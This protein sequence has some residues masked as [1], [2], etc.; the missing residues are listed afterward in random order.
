[1]PEAETASVPEASGKVK[2]RAA[3]AVP[4]NLK[5]LVPVPPRYR[6]RKG[7]ALEP[8]SMLDEP[9]SSDVLMATELR[10]DKAVFAPPLP[11]KQ[12]PLDVQTEYV[13]AASAGRFMVT[14]AV[15]V[16]KPKVVVKPPDVPV[17][18]LAAVPCR[19][20]TWLVAPAVKA[21]E[22]VIEFKAD[23]EVMSLLAPDAA[24]PKLLR[25]PA[26]VPLLVPPLAIG[27][28]PVKVI[29][30]VALR[31]TFPLAE[32]ASVPPAFGMVIVRSALSVAGCKVLIKAEEP[33]R[34]IAFPRTEAV[35][36]VSP[37]LPC[38]TS[39]PPMVM[40]EPDSV[41]ILSPMTCDPVNLARAPVV[42]PAVVTPPPVPAQ[43]PLE[44][45]S[46]YVPAES[47][48]KFKVTLAVGVTK[49]TVVTF[50]PF[51]AVIM[52]AAVPCRVK[53]W[54]VAPAVKAA[55]GVIVLRPVA[56]AKAEVEVMSPLAPLAAAPR[57]LRAPAAVPL[58]VPPLAI[59]RRP[60]KD[61]PPVALKAMF[62]EAETAIV[63]EASGSVM[64]R[65]PLVLAPVIRK[66]LVPGVP[67]VPAK[68]SVPNGNVP[69][70]RFT[71]PAT[72]GNS[73]VLMATLVRLL[74]AVF[75]APEAPPK[76]LP[77]EVQTL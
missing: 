22:G 14:L 46:V 27:K 9:E 25:A 10:L 32:T 2:V 44:A 69:D 59:G 12:L 49:P 39:A 76:Q 73:E 42:P 54:P 26:A 40:T 67:E 36:I 8:R 28:R 17:T 13:P 56:D 21:A 20:K 61:I 38:I 52:L 63:P 64:V 48:G 5:L 4:V 66:L 41:M 60:V 55:E 68:L 34:N 7:A 72:P 30:P 24:A 53:A 15:G 16:A 3:K 57:L 6:S 71:A 75:A 51:V 18:T 11:P 23:V 65:V 70:P 1:M 43:L 31:A 58:L 45:Q 37:P 33:S 62:P 35:P 77:L 74:R 50:A 19:V 29:S 47:A